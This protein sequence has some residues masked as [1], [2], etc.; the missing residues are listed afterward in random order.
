MATTVQ[1]W[2][3]GIGCLQYAE[4]FENEGFDEMSDLLD[5]TGEEFLELGVRRGH[6]RRMVK[7]L[8]VS[9]LADRRQ[10]FITYEKLAFRRVSGRRGRRGVY[11]CMVDGVEG[12]DRAA[13][14]FATK[15]PELVITLVS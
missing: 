9:S 5:M 12:R 15:S 4:M 7:S 1:E 11:T 3:E 14:D 13:A 10:F 2:L 8:K 6:M